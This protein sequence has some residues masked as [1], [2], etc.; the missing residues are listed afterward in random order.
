MFTIACCLVVGFG[1]GLDIVSDWFGCY[2]H[3]FVLVSIVIVT[4]SS[5]PVSAAKFSAAGARPTL[6]TGS[7]GECSYCVLCR[8]L[9]VATWPTHT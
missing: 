5:Q 8:S 3:V 7:S 9:C 2:A 1:L 4:L 6:V